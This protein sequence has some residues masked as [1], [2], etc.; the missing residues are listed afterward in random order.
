[1][2]WLWDDNDERKDVKTLESKRIRRSGTKRKFRNK[3]QLFFL[4]AELCFGLSKLEEKKMSI[5]WYRSISTALVNHCRNVHS[6]SAMFPVLATWQVSFR[7]SDFGTSPHQQPI[8][9]NH[10]SSVRSYSPISNFGPQYRDGLSGTP[11]RLVISKIAYGKKL[12]METIND[13]KKL[14]I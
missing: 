12:R 13:S 14:R 1:M 8:S 9:R 11:R 10:R 3:V 6:H 7:A 4:F 5:S 2:K